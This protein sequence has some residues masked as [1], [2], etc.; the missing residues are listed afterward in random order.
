M[1]GRKGVKKALESMGSLRRLGA[2]PN[3]MKFRELCRL[4]RRSRTVPL[5]VLELFSKVVRFAK[6]TKC[7]L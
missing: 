7:R 3:I 4:N 5:G 1:T 6:P 2:R